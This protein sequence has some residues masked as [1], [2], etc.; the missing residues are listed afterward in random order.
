MTT[1]ATAPLL[2]AI[3]SSGL[4][5]AVGVARGETVLAEISL[6]RRNVHAEQLAPL[7]DI[8]LERAGV[9]LPD[10]TAIAL[11]A[12]PGSFT[13]LRIGYALAKGLSFAAG[14]PIVEVPTLDVW[15][16]Q[17]GERT[18]PVV[19]IVDARREE[20]F[21]AVYDVGADSL[22]RRGEFRRLPIAELGDAL[23][24]N[25]LLCGCDALTL[26]DSLRAVLGPA[27]TFHEPAPPGPQPWSL[28]ALGARRLAAGDLADAADCEPLYLRTFQGQT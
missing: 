16:W 6:H 18:R 7:V 23:P 11:S 15:A 9:T 3:E 20:V 14:L 17:S 22:S 24:D 13:G 26:R 19:P 4:T 5:C 10:V 8:A 27:C 21:F 1:P 28:L 2:L 12:G 25:A